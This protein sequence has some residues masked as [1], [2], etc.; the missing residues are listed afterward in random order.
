ME[1][2]ELLNRKG[3]T[4]LQV[5][6]AMVIVSV[7]LLLLLNMAL[8]ALEDN[9]PATTATTS[10]RLLQ[11]KLEQLRASAHPIGGVDTTQGVRRAW[12][13]SPVAYN[14]LQIEVTTT[15]QDFGGRRLADTM[16]TYFNP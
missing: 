11:E 13:V 9:N 2:A 4:S 7:A 5:L 10:A 6:I 8:V 3:L 12:T 15:W 1:V 14:L 16:T